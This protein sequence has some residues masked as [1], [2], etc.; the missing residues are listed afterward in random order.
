MELM[1]EQMGR[2]VAL[3]GQQ[4]ETTARLAP[5][6]VQSAERITSRVQEAFSAVGSPPSSPPQPAEPVGTKGELTSHSAQDHS[7]TPTSLAESDLG[8]GATE[9]LRQAPRPKTSEKQAGKTA[10][11]SVVVKSIP[12]AK[13][14][15]RFYTS[16]RLPRALWD[17]AGFQPEDRL[18]LEWNGKTLNIERAVEG[19]VKPKSIGEASVILQSWKLGNLN[20]EKP[21]VTEADASLRLMGRPSR[22]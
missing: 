8:S 13:R 19:G 6:I 15:D 3:G 18:L 9:P 10:V 1:A 5:L 2:L 12:D 11:N 21:K 4:I 17:S 16:I 7:Q 14:S 20:F 22:S